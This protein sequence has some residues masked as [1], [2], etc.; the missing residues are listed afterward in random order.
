MTGDG[1][2]ASCKD[3]TLEVVETS[4]K[5]PVAEKKVKI[6]SPSDYEN[7]TARSPDLQVK[8][9]RIPRAKVTAFPVHTPQEC[10]PAKKVT[11]CNNAKDPTQWRS[12]MTTFTP[13][14]ADVKQ[15]QTVKGSCDEVHEQM[16]Y[17]QEMVRFKAFRRDSKTVWNEERASETD[18]DEEVEGDRGLASADES[19][20]IIGNVDDPRALTILQSLKLNCPCKSCTHHEPPSNNQREDDSDLKSSSPEEDR[21]KKW[22]KSQHRKYAET[23]SEDVCSSS[24]ANNEKGKRKKRSRFRVKSPL[25]QRAKT[26]SIVNATPKISSHRRTSFSFF[27]TLF[28][29]VFWPYVFLKANR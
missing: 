27:N 15:L 22:F 16:T 7:A 1:R 29:I 28:D 8:G 13:N 23:S 14:N 9:S 21:R 5:I 24:D 25:S 3:A 2:N 18:G 20:A 26:C 19:P 10:H 6:E 4:D 11:I 12:S 17:K